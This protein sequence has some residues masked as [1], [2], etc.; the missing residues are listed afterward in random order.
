MKPARPQFWPDGV[1]RVRR[2]ADGEMAGNRG[3]L[4]PGIEPVGLHA[5]G[6]IEIEADLH[7]EPGCEIP[8]S[9]QLPVGRPLHEFDEF[10]LGRIGALAQFGAFGLIGLPPWFRPFPPRLVEFVP[11]H[12]EAGEPRQQRLALGA[13]FLEILPAFRRRV[14]PEALER[15][16]AARAISASATPT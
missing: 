14:G 4:V 8:A 2:R 11:Q 5:D 15:Q 6:D 1:Q 10:D 16:R 7:A 12:L 9:P 3:L 13:K